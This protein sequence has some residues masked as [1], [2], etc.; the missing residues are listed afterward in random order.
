M[1]GKIQ[2]SDEHLSDKQLVRETLAQ[3]IKDF[4]DLNTG[5]DKLSEEEISFER[6]VSELSPLIAVMLDEYMEKLFNVLYKIDLPERRIREA[7]DSDNP[8]VNLSELI[9][10]RELQKVVI[11]RMFS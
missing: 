9:L 11:R 5:F 1:T 2:I 6:L 4:G 8:S 10:K 7:M 3:T